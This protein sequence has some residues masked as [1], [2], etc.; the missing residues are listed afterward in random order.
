MNLL[1]KLFQIKQ[2][3]H[4]VLNAQETADLY[5]QNIAIAWPSTV[6][7]AL[8]SIISS[9]DT[10]MVGTLGTAAIAAVGLTSQPR[11]ILLIVAQALCIGTTAI[12]ARRKGAGDQAGANSCLNQSLAVISVLG[13]LMTLLGYLG[14]SGL[15]VW[16]VPMKTPLK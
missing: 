6:E 8:M 10:A 7:G 13:V 14:R 4:S 12:C 15:C 5:R 1:H 11:M 3:D 16:P 9:V 2:P